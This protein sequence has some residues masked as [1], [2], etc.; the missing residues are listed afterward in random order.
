MTRAGA[1]TRAAAFVL[2]LIAV[3]LGLGTTGANAVPAQKVDAN[4]GALW[5][6]VLAT[7]SAQNPFGTGGDAFVCL[8]LGKVVAPFGPNGVASCTVKTGT[9][10]F[11]AA[12][13]FECSTFEGNGTSEADLRNCAKLNDA[14]TAPPVTVDGAPVPVTEAETGL[15]NITLPAGNIFGQ[16]AGTTGLSV[17]HGWATLLHPLT[18]GTHTITIGTGATAIETRIIVQPGR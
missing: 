12:A 8:D 7:P 14:Q 3:T 6:K 13:S 4:L 16:P 5:T 2:V 18:P 1:I 17:G 9:Q 15:L 11:V 10:I